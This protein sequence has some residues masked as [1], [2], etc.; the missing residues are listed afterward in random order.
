MIARQETRR[1]PR[2]ARRRALAA[3]AGALVV[4][5]GLATHLL[6]P[7]GPLSD[8]AGD[9]LYAALVYLLGVSL[10]PRARGWRV[11]IGAYAWCAF[12][13]LLQ[14]TALPA[15][16]AASFPPLVVVFGSVFAPQDLLLYA[17]G[18]V[19]ACAIDSAARRSA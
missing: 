17:A 14:L 13:E 10:V 9:A 12:V 8:A 5:A 16:W 1:P 11:A 19:A 15:S 6:A 18:V 7:E 4:A 3:A 2:V